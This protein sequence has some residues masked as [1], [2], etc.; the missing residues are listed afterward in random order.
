MAF[1]ELIAESKELDALARKIQAAGGLETQNGQL[2]GKPIGLSLE[3]MEDLVDRYRLWFA[4][5][6]TILPPDLATKFE[7]EY[8]GELPGKPKI[9]TFLGT[10]GATKGGYASGSGGTSH[11]FAPWAYPYA[12]TFRA[13]LQA[14]QQLLSIAQNRP[15][16]AQGL[17]D[18]SAK[19]EQLVRRFPLIAHQ[20]TQ[21]RRHKVNGVLQA[22]ETLTIADEYDVQDL[23]HA[24]LWSLFDDIRAEE[25][26]PS[27]A[28]RSARVDFLLKKEQVVL[29]AK[30]TRPD[31]QDGQIGE[32]LIIDIARYRA[33]PDCKTLIAFVYD[34]DRYISNPRGLEDDLSGLREGL[35]VKVIV[36]QG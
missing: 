25:W 19:V 32:E 24:L 6:V 14:Q 17:P 3:E 29:E 21:R 10:P 12:A 5:C 36:V 27:Y 8:E 16:A 31:L 11:S 20:L 2:V 28:G 4:R 22:R 34:P 9:K 30:M 7:A 1:D 15:P 35:M 18:A 13:P 33:L 23:L 26:T